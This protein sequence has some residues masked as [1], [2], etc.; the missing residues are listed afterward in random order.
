MGGVVTKAAGTAVT[1]A[2]STMRAID[3][4]LLEPSQE[5][6]FQKRAHSTARERS[7]VAKHEPLKTDLRFIERRND[8]TLEREMASMFVDVAG[9]G[10]AMGRQ[11]AK[12]MTLDGET[13][14]VDSDN[15]WECVYD[16]DGRLVE[17]AAEGAVREAARGPRLMVV[18]ILAARDIESTSRRGVYL[19]RRTFGFPR[20]IVRSHSRRNH[21]R[22]ASSLTRY[23]HH[24]FAVYNPPVHRSNLRSRLS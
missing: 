15:P 11:R 2:A 14:A 17:R 5:S 23:P 8:K 21:A 13:L 18:E 1:A 6:A 4:Q 24:P 19:L 16:R 7:W 12:T 9:A 10:G 22:E 20:S 3:D